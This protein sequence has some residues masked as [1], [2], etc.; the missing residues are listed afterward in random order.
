LPKTNL[1]KSTARSNALECRE[2]ADKLGACKDGRVAGPHV[3]VDRSASRQPRSVRPVRP[4]RA[5]ASRSLP[6]H[7]TVGPRGRP[8]VRPSVGRTRTQPPLPR[9]RSRA[10]SSPPLEEFTYLSAPRDVSGSHGERYLDGCVV[11]RVPGARP[12]G[13]N[14]LLTRADR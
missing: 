9:R 2:L 10:A 3:S 8:S 1:H 7:Y 14:V 4:A 13:V 11:L 12:A 5:R 6:V